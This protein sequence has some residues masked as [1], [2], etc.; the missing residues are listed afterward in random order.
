MKT[1]GNNVFNDIKTQGQK[2]CKNIKTQGKKDFSNNKNQ[3]LNITWYTSF[4][5]VKDEKEIISLIFKILA[6][7]FKHFLW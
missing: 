3:E 6:L 5:K 4:T 7:V 1:Q 2:D